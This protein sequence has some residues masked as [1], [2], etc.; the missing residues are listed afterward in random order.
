MNKPVKRKKKTNHAEWLQLFT[1]TNDGSGFSKTLGFVMLVLAGIGI[2]YI[3]SKRV[4]YANQFYH[5]VFTMNFLEDVRPG[6]KV[7]YQGALIVGEIDSIESGYDYH[8]VHA[9]IK[10]DFKIPK[11]GSSVSLKTWGYMGGKFLNVDVLQS[12]QNTESYKEDD[13]IPVKEITNTTI[14]MAEFY[15]MI[16]KS[17]NSELSPLEERLK[18]TREMAESFSKSKYANPRFMRGFVRSSAEKASDYFELLNTIGEETYLAL[19]DINVLTE[20]S[21]G[22]LR[23]KLPTWKQ[24]VLKTRQE[25]TYEDAEANSIQRD[26]WHEETMYY[27]TLNY[28]K[29][30]R[31]KLAE[32]RAAPYRLVFQEE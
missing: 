15:D 21:V 17:E 16:K 23:K 1:N 6:M 12:Y 30:V 19:S 20:A 32:Y 31:Q 14:I 24:T 9:R 5:V 10:K 13:E 18:E 7:R 25:F 4:A 29:Y 27:L 3:G 22:E 26:F 8:K 28:I 11:K 2:G